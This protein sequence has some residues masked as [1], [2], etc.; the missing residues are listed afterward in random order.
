MNDGSGW[1][2]LQIASYQGHVEIV[3]LLLDADGIDVK[4]KDIDGHTA[5]DV[6][7]KKGHTEIQTLLR[8]ASAQE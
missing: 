4:A 1:T 5:L 3:K 8:A 6:A 2:S 7:T